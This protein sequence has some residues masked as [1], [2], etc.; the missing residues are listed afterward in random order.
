LSGISVAVY[1][2]DGGTAPEGA[3]V[4]HGGFAIGDHNLPVSEVVRVV[5]LPAIEVAAAI[6]RGGDDGILAAWEALVRWIVNSG[7]RSRRGL[8]GAQLRMAR[9]RPSRQRHGTPTTHR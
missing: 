2:D 3:I 6:Y 5:N 4:L 8:P 9:R 1:E 7:Y